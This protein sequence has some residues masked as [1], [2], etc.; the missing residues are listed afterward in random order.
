MSHRTAHLVGKPQCGTYPGSS[1]PRNTGHD[2]LQ[3][4]SRAT[5]SMSV[6]RAASPVSGWE[7]LLVPAPAS[8]QS[9]YEHAEWR[10]L[11]HGT[12][13]RA[14]GHGRPTTGH[15]H[16]SAKSSGALS[17]SD[18]MQRSPT[19]SAVALLQ[20]QSAPLSYQFRGGLGSSSA[21]TVSKRV[22]RSASCPDLRLLSD[23][24]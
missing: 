7:S 4:L 21:R 5:T 9:I 22:T 2:G 19:A 24:Y 23:M 12:E 10:A 16:N 17:H 15:P 20:S 6:G 3:D 1:G 13:W 11:G 8:A 18:T 14:V